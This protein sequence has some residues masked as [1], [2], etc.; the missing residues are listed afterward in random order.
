MNTSD[1]TSTTALCVTHLSK[2]FPVKS[3]QG[4]KIIHAVRDISFSVTKGECVAF[5]G[6]N[7]AGKSTTI[8][9]I[10]AILYPTSGDISLLGMNP[11]TARKHLL[12]RI[13]VIFGQHSQLWFHLPAADSFR[14]IG[15]MYGLSNADIQKRQSYLA[16][17]FQIESFI[18]RPVRQLSLGERMRCEI[19]AS[20]IHQP[21]I[22]F[23]DEPTIGLD[24]T[25]KNIIRKT[26]KKLAQTE[27][28]TILLTSHDTGDIEEICHRVILINKGR[29]ILDTTL[30]ILKQK[31]ITEKVITAFYADG[32][33]EERRISVNS[34]DLAQEIMRLTQSGHLSDM[35][36]SNPP[37]EEIIRSLYQRESL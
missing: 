20:L 30:D 36:I 9:M 11:W 32:H 3:K 18:S 31:Y 24:I 16:R 19:V 34:S 1:T 14:L 35:S 25:A 17:L 6:P 7:G 26:L 5:I 2:S 8:K 12:P 13:G 4:N 21:E 28:M 37:L 15:K 33:K 27:G 23:L 22:L 29:L 10:T